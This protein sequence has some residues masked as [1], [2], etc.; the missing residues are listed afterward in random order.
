MFECK[1]S[2]KDFYM[3]Y[4]QLTIKELNSDAEGVVGGISV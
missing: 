1:Q 4:L 3:K 2:K